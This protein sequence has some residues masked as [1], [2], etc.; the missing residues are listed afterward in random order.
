MI[1][2]AETPPNAATLKLR[3]SR[4]SKTA[5]IAQAGIWIGKGKR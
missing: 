1:Y 4:P 3:K 5:A 2:D